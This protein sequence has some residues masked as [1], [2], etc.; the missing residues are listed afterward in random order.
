MKIKFLKDCEL[1][2]IEGYDESSDCLDTHSEIFHANEKFEVDEFGREG[3]KK[4]LQFGDGSVIMR[5]STELFEVV[6]A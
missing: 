6:E 5:I 1:E 3:N 4:D 2:V